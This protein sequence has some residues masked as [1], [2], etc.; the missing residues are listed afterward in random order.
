MKYY[1]MDG[2]YYQCE[3][4]AEWSESEEGCCEVEE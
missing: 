1:G 2:P 3:H 4:C